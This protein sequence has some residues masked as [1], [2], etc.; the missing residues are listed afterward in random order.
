MFRDKTILFSLITLHYHYYY[1]LFLTVEVRFVKRDDIY[2]SPC[3]EQD[4]C[5]INV[6]SYR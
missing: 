2:M 6:I 4:T 3:Y 1:Y 5:F